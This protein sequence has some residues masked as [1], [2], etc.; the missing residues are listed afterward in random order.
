MVPAAIAESECDYHVNMEGP[1]DK[2]DLG[3]RLRSAVLTIRTAAF[4]TICNVSYS[5]FVFFSAAYIVQYLI[6]LFA[7][8]AAAV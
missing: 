6:G 5:G 8:T 3:N 7:K 1:L 4:L 2:I